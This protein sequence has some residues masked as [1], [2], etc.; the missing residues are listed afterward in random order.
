MKVLIL[1]GSPREGQNTD[2]L[3]EAFIKGMTTN[4]KI[5]I[6]SIRLR[7]KDVAPCKACG[8]CKS[9]KACTIKDDMQMIYSHIESSRMIVLATPLYVNHVS[10]YTKS[11]M[12]RC[13]IYWNSKYILKDPIIPLDSKKRIGVVLSTA[14]STY[15]KQFEGLRSTCELFFK[16]VHATYEYELLITGTDKVSVINRKDI[17]KEAEQ[18]GR[19]MTKKLE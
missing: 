5:E 2:T 8:F 15:P 6:I 17:L 7:E 14:G 12:D 19:D 9:T 10:A 3:V 13:Q 1:R 11:M 4:S 16:G 18:A